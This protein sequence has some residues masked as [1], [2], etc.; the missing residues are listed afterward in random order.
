MFIIQDD[1]KIIDKFITGIEKMER[2]DNKLT[3]AKLKFSIKAFKKLS[4]KEIKRLNETTQALFILS[5]A[6]D[7]LITCKTTLSYGCSKI[8][9]KKQ[10]LQHAVEVLLFTFR[11][12]FS[13]TFSY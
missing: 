8:L 5:K 1:R 9:Y 3:L 12:T 11:F 13:M 10:K 4:N 6:L 7:N 2:V